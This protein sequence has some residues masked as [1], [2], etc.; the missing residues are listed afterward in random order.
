[1][2]LWISSIILLLLLSLGL[3]QREKSKRHNRLHFEQQKDL[4]KSIGLNP[5]GNIDTTIGAINKDK[6]MEYRQKEINGFLA[7]RTGKIS[8]VQDDCLGH[9]LFHRAHTIEYLTGGSK[10]LRKE[11]NRLWLEN[12][13]ID[14]TLTRLKVQYP[15][16]KEIITDLETWLKE[17]NDR[18]DFIKYRKRKYIPI[19]NKQ[20]KTYND[21]QNEQQI[22][23]NKN[24]KKTQTQ[25][26][27][28]IP[29]LK[30]E[31]N[32]TL[33]HIDKQIDKQEPSITNKKID[34]SHIRL[35]PISEAFAYYCQYG[36]F[37]DR[38]IFK[39]IKTRHQF[40]KG[41]ISNYAKDHGK[42]REDQYKNAFRSI[43]KIDSI[44]QKYGH[45]NNHERQKLIMPMSKYFRT[46]PDM[47]S[48]AD[49]KRKVKNFT[50]YAKTITTNKTH[51]DKLT[52]AFSAY[53]SGQ[54]LH[55]LMKNQP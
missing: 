38:N 19:L 24:G 22:T 11:L 20:I 47:K 35:S 49:N 40:I 41:I 7:T 33:T 14:K 55:N 54:S 2:L 43:W 1:M 32:K 23:E 12:E 17:K 44:L 15:D 51:P 3:L 29:K 13:N 31:F 36:S 10:K 27:Q 30:K 21:I 37:S 45:F 50:D 4:V 46:V 18:Y 42:Q 9:E 52:T 5:H 16:A 53:I 6:I 34:Y 48:F 39:R 8:V 28:K 26:K 25:T